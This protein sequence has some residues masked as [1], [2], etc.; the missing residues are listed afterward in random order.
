MSVS[1]SI[2]LSIRPKSTSYCVPSRAVIEMSGFALTTSTPVPSLSDD[3]GVWPPIVRMSVPV[4]TGPG[5]TAVPSMPR[6]LAVVKLP[7]S[8]MVRFPPPP[9]SSVTTRRSPST[10]AVTFTSV[11]LLMAVSTSPSV[12][13]VVRSMDAVSPWLS[14]IAIRPRET[15]VPALRSASSVSFPT[16]PCPSSKFSSV[17][18]TGVELVSMK[19]RLT[20]WLDETSCLTTNE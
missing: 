14:V 20:F 18:P 2:A 7:S 13:T 10:V 16:K 9:A 5:P 19:P 6:S 3:S 8:A 12:V 15:P 1:S 11:S 17:S 4:R